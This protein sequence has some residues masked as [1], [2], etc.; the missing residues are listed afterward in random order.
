MGAIN[1][2]LTYLLTKQEKFLNQAKRWLLT[3]VGYKDW[4]HAHLVNVDL[5]ASWILFGLSL[6]YDWLKP[7]LTEEERKRILQKLEHHARI[8]YEYRQKTYGSGW[9]TNFYQNHNW[10]NMTGLAAAGYLLHKEEYVRMAR[11]NF[12]RVYALMPED[13]SNYEGVVYWRYGGMWLFVYAHLLKVQEGVDFFKTCDYL[14]NTFYYRLY[15]AC[16]DFKQQMNFGDCHDRYSGHPACVYYKVA[17][18]YGDGY[19]QKLGNMVVEDFLT[20]E[21]TYSKVKPGILPEA[22]FEFLWYAPEIEEKD[23]DSLPRV[24]WFKDLGLLAM[25]S[26]WQQDA[27]VLTIKCSAPGGQ[28]QWREGWKILQNEGIDLFSLSHHHPDNL[29]YI[30]SS[31][32]EY[33]TC[34]D[35]YNRNLMPDN[36]NVLLVDGKWTDAVNVND[37]YMSSVK[38]R[39]K[40]DKE[41]F[42]PELYGGCVSALHIDGEL[43]LYRAETASIYPVGLEMREASR[44]L[45]T[46]GLRFWAFADILSSGHDHT[47]TVVCNTDRVAQKEGNSYHYKMDTG[48]IFYHVFSDGPIRERQYSQEIVSVMTTQAPDDVCR[49]FMQTLVNENVTPKSTQI[50]FETFTFAENDAVIQSRG[51]TLRLRVKDKT[52]RITI[53]EYDMLAKKTPIHVCV[54][55]ETG[56]D[57]EYLV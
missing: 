25:R 11:E 6:G 55:D 42:R 9:S 33:F 15:Q 43:V 41:I 44:L 1:L 34:E 14:K 36:H 4:G 31:G 24:R 13:G 47:Y 38:L 20:D 40:A 17:A 35:G 5:S 18:E 22:I 3:G 19:A 50:F 52:Y 30:F 10:I 54:T 49:T 39:Q 51:R 23:F 2:S 56:K 53:G 16:G 29:S 27:R 32:S 7:A 26:S 8:I 21:A 28:K 48:D 57:K 37:P 45:L 12:E 46:D